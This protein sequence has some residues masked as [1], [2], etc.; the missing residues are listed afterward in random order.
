FIRAEDTEAGGENT[1]QSEFGG[2][3]VFGRKLSPILTFR[4][5][6]ARDSNGLINSLGRAHP[7]AS[8]AALRA[9]SSQSASCAM[10]PN[11]PHSGMRATIDCLIAAFRM[12]CTASTIASVTAC[13]EGRRAV[14]YSL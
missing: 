2:V 3:A 1:T 14:K 11:S 9:A 10:P 8:I 13:S 12:R 5:V 4:S 6:T 7:P